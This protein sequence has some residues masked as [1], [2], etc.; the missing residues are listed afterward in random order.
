MFE[1]GHL[2]SEECAPFKSKTF[3]DKCGNY[4]DCKKIA[5]INKSYWVGGSYMDPINELQIRQELLMNG[6]IATNM[7]ADDENFVPYKKGILQ[8]LVVK[9][10][11]LGNKTAIDDGLIIPREGN[12]ELVQLDMA[13]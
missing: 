2:V 10:E 6:P 13:T 7:A 5:K 3:G 1:Q 4:K 9:Y 11:P 12:I 8:E